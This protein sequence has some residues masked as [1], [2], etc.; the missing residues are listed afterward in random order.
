VKG[1]PLFAKIT[2]NDFAKSTIEQHQAITEAIA[3]GDSQGAK[4][5][6]IAHLNGNRKGILKALTDQKI[7]EKI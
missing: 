4:Y 6:M 1:I 5:G 3:A 2:K 7:K